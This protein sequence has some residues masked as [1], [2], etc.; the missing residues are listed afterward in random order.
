M[1]LNGAVHIEE[2]ATQFPQYALLHSV[3]C[4]QLRLI[5][6]LRNCGCGCQF[7]WQALAL[8]GQSKWAPRIG[9]EQKLENV[10]YD[11]FSSSFP[12]IIYMHLCFQSNI[13]IQ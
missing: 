1:L 9:S 8:N 13:S 5:T 6:I 11:T 10:R 2:T 3:T 12:A 4:V 7:P